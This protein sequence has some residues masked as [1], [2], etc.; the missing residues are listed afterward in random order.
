VYKRVLPKLVLSVLL[1]VVC[2]S[3]SPQAGPRCYCPS[4]GEFE[5]LICASWCNG[6]DGVYSASC[7]HLGPYYCE[8]VDGK[9]WAG[10][11]PI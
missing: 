10:I 8:C 1:V 11:D 7:I 9:Y 3:A 5:Y 2:L 6:H 4:Q